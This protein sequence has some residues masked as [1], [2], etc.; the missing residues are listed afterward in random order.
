M[1]SGKFEP[2]ADQ[3]LNVKVR[4]SD[5]FMAEC[6]F[7][8]GGSSLQFNINQGLWVCF[9]CDEKGNAKRLVQKLGGVYTDPTVSVEHIREHM[10]R[11][12]TRMK[13]RNKEQVY[14]E[15][16]YLARYDFPDDY[17]ENERGFS[18]ETIE[19]FQ[20]GYD[21]VQDRH[22]IPYRTEHGDLLGVIQRRVGNEFPRYIYPEGFDRKRSLFGSWIIMNSDDKKIALVEGSTDTI[23]LADSGLPSVAQYGSAISRLQV[24]LLHRLGVREIVLFYD[25]DE[26]GRKAEE[27]SRELID[28]MILRAVR[29]DP[30]KYCWHKKLC[31][32]GEHT[33]RTIGK[34]ENKKLCRCGRKHEMDP[35]SLSHKERVKMYNNAVLVGSKKW[36]R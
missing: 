24:R 12:R 15:D 26:A 8:S 17:W 20:L 35:G 19:R 4:G 32:C 7:C 23:S 2:L 27:K 10:D 34:C 5:E 36:K 14:L 28:G 13:R 3:Y 11:I 22:T 33:W 18:Q 25:Y 21:P 16:S 9:R 31:A 6:P 1:V 30:R 29:Y